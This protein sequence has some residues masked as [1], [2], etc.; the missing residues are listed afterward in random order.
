MNEHADLSRLY[1][2]AGQAGQPEPS[3]ALDDAILGAARQAAQGAPRPVSLQQ[4]QTQISPQ[5]QARP[6]RWRVPFAIAATA[7]LSAT[8]TLLVHDQQASV[9]AGYGAP[10]IAPAEATRANH[11]TQADARPAALEAVPSA[12]A[13]AVVAAAPRPASPAAK[14][15]VPAMAPAPAAPSLGL[16]ADSAMKAAPAFAPEPAP[17][18]RREALADVAEARNAAPAAPAAA[19]VAPAPAIAGGS[20]AAFA[21]PES[22]PRAAKALAPAAAASVADTAADKRSSEARSPES[23]VAEIRE[24]RLQGQN[25]EAE[26]RLAELRRAYPTYPLPEDL[27]P[28]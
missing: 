26:R 4:S 13:G 24:L 11:A 12:A 3:A 5:P 20:V 6:G 9:E 23:W 21:A 16:A 2:Q 28:H 25:A 18:A 27:K 7:L 10:Q 19:A 8:V 1:R 22:R 14:A 17:V 15:A